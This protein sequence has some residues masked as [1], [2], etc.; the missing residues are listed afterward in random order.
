[1]RLMRL[2]VVCLLSLGIAVQGYAGVRVMDASCP[3]LH[4]EVAAAAVEDHAEMDHAHLH[5]ADMAH[6]GQDQSRTDHGKAGHGKQCQHDVGCQ[7]AGHAIASTL[8]V[9]VPAPSVMQMSA[10]LA[11]SFRSHIPALLARPPALT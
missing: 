2:F 10:V 3:M 8:V 4:P 1:M 9:Q 7:P 11:P 5:H 6:A